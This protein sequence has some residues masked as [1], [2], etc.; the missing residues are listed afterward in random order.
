MLVELCKLHIE[1]WVVKEPLTNI[2]E[3]F[4][5]WNHDNLVLETWIKLE[6]VE[7]WILDGESLNK[8]DGKTTRTIY[9][10]MD[11]FD[12]TMFTTFMATR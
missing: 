2:V 3:T 9:G 7:P 5:W 8:V 1:P 10:T 11:N 12:E 4:L 6:L